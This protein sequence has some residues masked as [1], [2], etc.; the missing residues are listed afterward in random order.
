MMGMSTRSVPILAFLLIGIG[1]A[2]ILHAIFR[3]YLDTG[4][5]S[6]MVGNGFQALGRNSLWFFSLLTELV[7]GFFLASI[8]IKIIKN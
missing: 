6:F 1:I 3:A 7:G 4:G 2:T 8:G 5:L